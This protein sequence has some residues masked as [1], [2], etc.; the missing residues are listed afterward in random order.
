MKTLR[1]PA[2][3]KANKEQIDSYTKDLDARLNAIHVPD[4]CQCEDLKCTE[5]NHSSERDNLVLD[6]LVNMIEANHCNIPLVGGKTIKSGARCQS[7]SI[8]G[9][10]EQ[11]LP[12]QED[13]RFW[14]SVWRSAGRPGLGALHDIMARTRNRYHYSIRKAKKNAEYFRAKKLFEASEAGSIDL[15]KE[16]KIIRKGGAEE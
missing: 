3:Y 1:K 13:A 7:S 5:I 6:I 8:P 16:M 14:H 10:R 12:F 15:L 9:W 11:V 4:S 2:W